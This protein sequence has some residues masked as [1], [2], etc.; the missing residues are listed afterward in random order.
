[1]SEFYS[2][3][4]VTSDMVEPSLEGSTLE[5]AME[6]KRIFLV[7]LSVMEGL[8]EGEKVNGSCMVLTMIVLFYEYFDNENSSATPSTAF[9]T[10]TTTT[11]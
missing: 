7:D 2:S 8:E 6:Q 3:F 10:I 5:E 11:S 1:M 4:G 9:A